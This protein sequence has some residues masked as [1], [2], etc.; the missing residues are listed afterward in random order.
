MKKTKKLV[1]SAILSSLGVVILLIGGLSGLLDISSACIVSF[2]LLFI[3]VEI[4]QLYALVSYAVISALAFLVCGNN[5]FAP[6]CFAVM[7]GPMAL[8]KN[9]FEKAGKAL[10]WLLKLA[11]PSVT[12][13]ITY[14]IGAELLDLPDKMWLKVVY[15]ALVFVTVW[16]THLL[17][18]VMTRIYFYKYRDKISKYLK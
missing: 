18:T 10:S 14:I 12:L 1:I 13:S 15:A 5:L 16:L 4:G 11:L 2:I 7:F 17:Y 9:L 8:T 6:L 3:S